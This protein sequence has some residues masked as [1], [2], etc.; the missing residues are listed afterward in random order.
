[1]PGDFAQAHGDRSSAEGYAVSSCRT[2]HPM[3]RSLLR[4]AHREGVLRTDFRADVASGAQADVERRYVPV[5]GGLARLSPIP[6]IDME[7]ALGA[8][9]KA[10]AA[11][12]RGGASLGIPS[13]LYHGITTRLPGRGLRS[14]PAG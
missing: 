4:G 9:I 10:H 14:G 6:G 12:L 2:T 5:L 1:M 3:R 11:I 7:Y 13:Y 8:F